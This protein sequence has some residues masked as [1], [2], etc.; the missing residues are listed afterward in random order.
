MISALFIPEEHFIL[1]LEAEV[2]E[3]WTDKAEALDRYSLG[4]WSKFHSQYSV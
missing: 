1:L 4:M 3:L 2:L